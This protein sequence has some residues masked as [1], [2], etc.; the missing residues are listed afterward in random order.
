M[1]PALGL[2]MANAALIGQNIGAKNMQRASDIA[3]MSILI[4]F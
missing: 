4:S 2:S 3:K 1:I